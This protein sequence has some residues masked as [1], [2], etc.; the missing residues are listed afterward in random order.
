MGEMGSPHMGKMGVG[1][2]Y[3]DDEPVDGSA[4]P[5]RWCRRRRRRRHRRRRR[6]ALRVTRVGVDGGNPHVLLAMFLENHHWRLAHVG[7][8]HRIDV[9]DVI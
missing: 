6:R 3:L 4:R 9:G 1:L 7:P 5:V 8:L 2:F